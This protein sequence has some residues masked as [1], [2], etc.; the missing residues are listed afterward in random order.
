MEVNIRYRSYVG[1][2]E[3]AIDLGDG[4]DVEIVSP[5]DSGTAL[6][7]DEIVKAL[8]LPFEPGSGTLYIIN[9]LDRPTPTERLFALLASRYPK[10]LLGDVVI[11]T[12]A[13][14]I[15]GS[16]EEI[17]K[18]LLGG[19]SDS[20]SGKIHFH[21]STADPMTSVGGTPRGTVVEVSSRLFEYDNI[22][23]LGSVEP[24]WFAGYTGGRKSI[25]PGV[26]SFE[27]IRM[28]HSLALSPDAGPTVTVGN[29]VYEDLQDAAS[30]VVRKIEGDADHAA[31]IGIN[32]ISRENEIYGISCGPILDSIAS[33][34]DRVEEI[35]IR[36]AEPS[37]I[38]V[39]VAESPMDRDLYQ[40]MKS[41]ENV[42]GA[43]KEGGSYILVASCPDG[44]GPPHF[45][46]TMELASERNFIEKRL[47][48]EYR[49]G[50]HKFK[51]PFDF[52]NRGGTM[53][54]VSEALSRAR[55]GGVG[56][57]TICETV[58]EAVR[59]EMGRHENSK[60]DIRTLVVKDAVNLVVV[61]K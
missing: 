35:Y 59:I 48:G 31:V 44:V 4:A 19:L 22:I 61:A 42:R 13:H 16:I 10:A 52:I 27:T 25:V 15:S 58:E 38:A 21:D 33:L 46:E 41:F 40:A 53:T 45:S 55:G 9:D 50:D 36:K 51:N 56:F 20:F 34:F 29:P 26:A 39:A 37:D 8:D 47:A 11:A 2:R 7:D 14:K 1:E 24:H 57:F 3:I 43:I 6:S 60:D 54:V 30:L 12:G 28:N 5:L 32:V 49:L 17:G 18:R 23:A